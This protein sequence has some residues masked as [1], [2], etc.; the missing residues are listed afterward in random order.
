MAIK[1]SK[2]ISIIIPIYNEAENIEKLIENLEKIKNHCEILFIDGGSSDG[3]DKIIEKNFKLIY[4]SKKGRANQMNYGASLA[5][6]DIL[7]FLHGDSFLEDKAINEIYRI[8]DKGYKVGCFRIKFDSRNI[9]MKVCGLM[10]NLRVVLRNIAFG[11]QGIF[12]RRDYFYELGGFLEI[13]LMEDYQLSM[14]IKKDK[15]KIALARR[16][17]IT[18]ERRFVKNGRLKTMAKMQRLQHMYRRGEDIE[19]ISN[20]YK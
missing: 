15:E 8:I 14:D 3:S 6:G 20:L 9:L 16:K 10:S 7:L 12:I 11:D 5:K 2:K 1:T 17:I 19:K 18:S 13:P 4:S